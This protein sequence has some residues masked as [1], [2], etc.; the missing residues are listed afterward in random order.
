M[1]TYTTTWT[2]TDENG[3]HI[4]DDG[5]VIVSC[6]ENGSL[7]TSTCAHT[8]VSISDGGSSETPDSVS[9]VSP[10]DVVG[11]SSLVSTSLSSLSAAQPSEEVS[12]TSPASTTEPSESFS[13]DY[14]STSEV[15][16][17]T[18]CNDVLCVT[19][20][21]T[22]STTTDLDGHE[23]T[24]SDVVIVT[25]NEDNGAQTTT[26]S[27]SS[28]SVEITKTSTL[29]SD[30]M[31]S[32]LTETSTLTDCTGT[33]C[34]ISV[35]PGKT[36]S[37]TILESEPAQTYP[38]TYTTTVCETDAN[39]S[40]ATHTI[41]VC[42]T[43]DSNGVPQVSEIF[44]SVI[45]PVETMN[46]EQP[47]ASIVEDGHVSRSVAGE[48]KSVAGGIIETSAD[49]HS[50]MFSDYY[51]EAALS[52]NMAS[53]ESDAHTVAEMSVLPE[54][55]HYSEGNTNDVSSI[56]PSEMTP[57]TESVYVSSGVPPKS[58]TTV[59]GS[60]AVYRLGMTCILP[61]ALLVL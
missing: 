25:S 31:C 49:V 55:V 8:S 11:G 28:T 19:S 22:L 50:G 58:I 34:H 41:V 60:G 12:W 47:G 44:E 4:T 42:E 6:D 61:L 48:A 38:A 20:F 45:E 3:D 32:T 53:Q 15:S 39:G 54:N 7:T 17:T 37:T 10:S 14:F 2:T 33:V 30:Q 26:L 40:V 27:L 43:T 51:G 29:C 21:T 46:P 9:S 59:E 13:T 35:E 23:V 52:D 5:V 56:S 24:R 1:T 18:S 16:T 36:T 57:E